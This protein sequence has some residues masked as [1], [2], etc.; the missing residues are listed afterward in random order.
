MRYNNNISLILL[1][2][3]FLRKILGGDR[4]NNLI[5]YIEKE[6]VLIKK[7]IGK[8]INLLDYGCGKLD[9]TLFLK[10]KKLINKAICVDN[11]ELKYKKLPLNVKYMNL[12]NSKMTF[13]KNYFNLAIIIDV[14]HHIGINN[15][16]KKLKTICKI[17]E[18]VIIKDHF[19]FNYLSRQLL[20]LADW[21]GNY[22][23]E[24]NIPKKYFT[25]EKWYRLIKK[26]KLKQIKIIKNVIQHKGLFSLILPSKHQ[27]ISIIRK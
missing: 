2:F 4:F 18:Y 11:Y 7:K 9:F 8:K 13:K 20:R 25:E 24:V 21:F 17:S 10:K 3:E 5:G 22:G 26:S 12:S 6:V 27:F 15:L 1:T 19:E 14:L 23:T 16:E